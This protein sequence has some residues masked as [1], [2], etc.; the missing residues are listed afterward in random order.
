MFQGLFDSLE[1]FGVDQKTH[2]NQPSPAFASFAMDCNH[3]FFQEIVFYNFQ[4]A[5][6][7]VV[8]MVVTGQAVDY[9]LLLLNHSL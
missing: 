6:L 4:F 8:A 7:K 1:H 3:R 5:L 2:D 9:V